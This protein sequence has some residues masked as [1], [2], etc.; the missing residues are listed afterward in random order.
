M[1][2][3][4]DVNTTSENGPNPDAA[5]RGLLGLTVLVAAVWCVALGLS[6]SAALPEI[7]GAAR[8]GLVEPASVRIQRASGLTPELLAA[9]RA[10]LPADGR[11][12]LYSPYGGA[13]FELDGA[14]PRG[15]PA[16]QVRTLFERAKNL[17]YPAPRDVH[18]ARDPAEL[19]SKL[20]ADLA[21][22]LLVVD[23]TQGD[24]PLAVGGRYE[25]LHTQALGTARL[26]LWRF[27]EAR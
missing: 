15:E 10:T 17:L 16:R 23:G 9:I 11:L 24:E 4:C 12:V 19:R 2:A 3:E 6:T 22:R 21:G 13:E 18:F 1:P 26:R 20:G 14:D 7:V 5:P 25:L 27:A 8:R